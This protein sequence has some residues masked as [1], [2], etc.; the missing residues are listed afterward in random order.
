MSKL[1]NKL[2]IG[3]LYSIIEDLL[4][5][6]EFEDLTRY[7]SQKYENGFEY[8]FVIALRI[9]NH[10]F[11]ISMKR[12]P[13]IS[14]DISCID[15]NKT[16]QYNTLSDRRV[17]SEDYKTDWVCDEHK[18]FIF[19]LS[20]CYKKCSNGFLK[21]K[22]LLTELEIFRESTGVDIATSNISS[23]FVEL[24]FERNYNRID[25]VIKQSSLLNKNLKVYSVL[26]RLLEI[27]LNFIFTERDYHGDYDIA[28][29]KLDYYIVQ[30]YGVRQVWNIINSYNFLVEKKHRFFQETIYSGLSSEMKPDGVF[31]FDDKYISKS[32]IIDVKLFSNSILNTSGVYNCIA[33]R[34]QILG[35]SCEFPSYLS[36][37]K[38]SKKND[39]T[40][41]A[42]PKD[43]THWIL[44][45]RVNATSSEK[46]FSGTVLD[47]SY[48]R[49]GVY[50]IDLTDK[51]TVE[52]IKKQLNIFIS[53]NVLSDI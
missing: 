3:F 10:T 42:K 38:Y 31:I 4:S 35:Y 7:S 28:I 12:C 30:Q 2:V 29:S 8:I 49:I 40:N 39:F 22:S 53:E 33:S 32:F 37:N 16:V 6:N 45:F 36:R 26:C 17:F 47:L 20:Y 25:G 13:S 19:L 46:R 44:H 48:A 21:T 51:M 11:P 1:P 24:I 34:G 52:D 27:V 41:I 50:V 18:L 23:E 15:L 43:F 5:S 14:F 9:L